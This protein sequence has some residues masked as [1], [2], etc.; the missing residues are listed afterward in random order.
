VAGTAEASLVHLD[1]HVVCW[2]YEGRIDLLSRPAR[3]AL[4]HAQTLGVSP[5]VDLELQLL[6]ESGRLVEGPAT[7]LPSLARDIGLQPAES[8]FETVVAAA[9]DV[10]WTRD[11]FDRL[12]VASAV[13]AHAR[14]ITKDRLVRKHCPLA[15]W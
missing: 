14:L 8:P 15:L 6:H 12:I 9:R 3:E 1:T 4:E 5:I 10:E 11:P 2:L 7:V 13:I